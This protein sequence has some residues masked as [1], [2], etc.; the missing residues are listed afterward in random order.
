MEKFGFYVP[1]YDGNLPQNTNWESSWM[2]FFNKLLAG[3]AHLDVEANGPWDE[4][5]M[6][7]D[8]TLNE[9]VPRLLGALEARGRTVKP[10]PIYGDL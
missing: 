7:V 4:L 6:A 10:C 2:I 1:T 5:Q 8:Q 9:I 3:I